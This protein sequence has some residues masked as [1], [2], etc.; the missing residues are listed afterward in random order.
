[1]TLWQKIK[2][3]IYGLAIV[4]DEGLNVLIGK[5]KADVPLAANPHATLS[6]RVAQMRAEGS[7]LGCWACTALTKIFRAFGSKTTDHCADALKDFPQNL[8][9]D[10]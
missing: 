4:A 7:K 5:D 3:R 1:M 2:T 6:Q 9:T 8:P 10:G